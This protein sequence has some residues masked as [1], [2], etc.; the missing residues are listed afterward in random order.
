MSIRSPELRAGL[1]RGRA[2]AGAA[3]LAVALSA[4]APGDASGRPLGESFFDDFAVFDEGRWYVSDGWSNG[5]HQN[6]Q[7]S[8]RAVTHAPGQVTLGFLPEA[9]ATH[10]YL[11]GEIQTR[12]RFGYGTYEAR[13]RSDDGSGLNAA[14]FTYIGPVHGERHD[15]IDFEILTANLNEV[16][17]NT[18]VDG[19]AHHGAVYPLPNPANAEFHVYSFV[20]EPGVLRW[21]VDGELIH[22]VESEILPERPQKIYLSLWGTETLNDWMGPFDPPTRPKRMVIDWVAF[23]ALGEPCR[24]EASVLCR[25]AGD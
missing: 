18:Y 11:C 22:T 7:W 19:E 8:R 17:V 1:A 6:C 21:F 16:T 2:A 4:P 12:P 24:F 13:I 25:L 20:W 23:T 15:E 10:A 14:F 5:D 3:L 9:S